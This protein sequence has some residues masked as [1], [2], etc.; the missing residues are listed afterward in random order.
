[1]DKFSTRAFVR[2]TPL[3]AAPVVLAKDSIVR[4]SVGKQPVILAKP[5]GDI[6]LPG[7][8]AEVIARAGKFVFLAIA[9]PSYVA[10]YTLPKWVLTGALPFLFQKAA[11]VTQYT[12]QHLN[13]AYQWVQHALAETFRT[14][15]GSIN[16]SLKGM[17]GQSTAIFDYL[18]GKMSAFQKAVV[19]GLKEAA[20]AV[21]EPVRRILSTLQALAL[22]T[23]KMLGAILSTA[24]DSVV[25]I[26]K[27]AFAKVQHHYNAVVDPIK[28][29]IT[30]KLQFIKAQV[31]AASHWLSNR[32]KPLVN[33]IRAFFTPLLTATRT[34][35]NKISK[36]LSSAIKTPLLPLL[37]IFKNYISSPL[38]QRRRSTAETL[39]WS[40]QKAKEKLLALHT[41]SLRAAKH[42]N[43]LLHDLYKNRKSILQSIIKWIFRVLPIIPIFFLIM[44]WIIQKILF[45]LRRLAA[46]IEKIVRPLIAPLVALYRRTAAL[47]HRQYTKT[48]SFLKKFLSFFQRPLTTILKKSFSLL[49]TSAKEAFQLLS[50]CGL[51]LK[52]WMQLVTEIASA[53]EAKISPEKK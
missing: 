28:Q 12:L 23:A 33:K 43:T 9:L 37:R 36:T 41:A 39:R 2:P 7:A 30:P 44:K 46:R 32:I 42:L 26:L 13:K 3:P 18:R 6:R 14:I 47:L 50:W 49:A 40:K 19:K 22:A 38:Q 25:S 11:D 4:N 51:L 48:L 35:V 24:K 45:V 27:K 31:S 34:I 21:A 5:A 29:W 16:W 52:F 15:K 10:L 53:I 17:E 20:T 1:M 8:H